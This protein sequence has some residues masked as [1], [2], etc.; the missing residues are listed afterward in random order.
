[1]LKEENS[2][3][4]SPG[5]NL[6]SPLNTQNIQEQEKYFGN[7][8]SVADFEKIEEIGEGTYGRVCKNH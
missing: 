6:T 4:E 5:N 8:R 1:M 7:C 3:Q 2:Q